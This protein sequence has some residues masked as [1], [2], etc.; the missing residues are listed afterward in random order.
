M[1]LIFFYFSVTESLQYL[2]KLKV[3]MYASNKERV[4]VGVKRSKIH[5]IQAHDDVLASTNCDGREVAAKRLANCEIIYST[6]PSL[7]LSYPPLLIAQT[8]NTANLIIQ[9]IK[10][11]FFRK[12]LL[13]DKL[14]LQ[15][16]FIWN[17]FVSVGRSLYSSRIEEFIRRVESKYDNNLFYVCLNSTLLK[18]WT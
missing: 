8:S 12:W 3:M 10:Y 5:I 6:I 9:S 7:L 18:I 14:N 2:K 13:I 1:R 15:A 11:L 17:L 16:F 4:E